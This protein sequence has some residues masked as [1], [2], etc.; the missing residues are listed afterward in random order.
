VDGRELH[1]PE[2]DCV[3]RLPSYAQILA[4]ERERLVKETVFTSL[5]L[6]S[7]IFGSVNI[8]QTQ[9]EKLESVTC[10]RFALSA[11]CDRAAFLCTTAR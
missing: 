1:F 5:T 11:A 4:A 7:V 6:A 9:T 2:S 10:D 8:Y 3:R